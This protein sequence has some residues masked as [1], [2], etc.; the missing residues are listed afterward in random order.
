[1]PT[2]LSGLDAVWLYL[3]TATAH[4][5]VGS[6]LVLDPS[7]APEPLTRDRALEYIEQRLHLAPA[8]RRRV[9]SVP[10]RI[11]HPVW[12]DD[13]D[14][15]LRYHVR[16]AALPSPGGMNELAEY[17]ADVMSRRLDRSRPLWELHLVEGLEGGRM[18]LVTKTHHAAVDGVSGAELLA[19]ILQITPDQPAPEPPSVEWRPEAEPGDLRL[20]LAAGWRMAATPAGVVRTARRTVKAGTRIV[21]MRTGRGGTTPPP[22]PFAAPPTPLN[23]SIGPHRLLSLTEQ[24]L[25]SVKTVKRAFGG[26]VNDVILTA[27]AGALR[28]YLLSRDEAADRPLV[29]MVPISVHG[30]APQAERPGGNQISMML[31]DLPAD[32]PDPIA[33]LRRVSDGTAGAKEQHGALGAETLQELAELTPAGVA[34]MAARVYTRVRGAD[35]HRPIWNV[36]VS[37]VPGPRIPLYFAGAKVEAMYPIGPVHEMCG[38]NI[39]IFSYQDMVYVGL[40][41]DRSLVPDVD[42]IG[43]AVCAEIEELA[44]LA[45]DATA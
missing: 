28:R 17:A 2:R 9:A 11:D 8:F 32:E 38:L 29:G 42:L 22:A 1:M 36:V 6:V 44:K 35:R 20:L 39:T 23:G 26:T 24:S 7:D 14:F 40:N 30:D 34:A 25:E 3:E 41:A 43:R 12:F 4:M 21:R 45:A 16:R 19:A 37:N 15:D 31:V 33:R 10:F 18:A 13:P 5:H 27:V